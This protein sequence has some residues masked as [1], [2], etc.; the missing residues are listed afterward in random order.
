MME[1][2]LPRESADYTA[3]IRAHDRGGWKQRCYSHKNVI[4]PWKEK[5]VQQKVTSGKVGSR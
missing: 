5:I 1:P 2:I 4:P 3:S